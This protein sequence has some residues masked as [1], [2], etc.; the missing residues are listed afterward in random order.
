MFTF[1]DVMRDFHESLQPLG[2][3]HKPHD[4]TTSPK[5]RAILTNMP[6]LPFRPPLGIG[7]FKFQI[8]RAIQSVL[9]SKKDGSWLSDDLFIGIS[10]DRL[11][12]RFP[13]RHTPVLVNGKNCAVYNNSPCLI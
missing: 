9:R 6:A 11:S 10:I 13:T 1:S 2:F 8:G 12:T 5:T 7:G 4:N 3:A